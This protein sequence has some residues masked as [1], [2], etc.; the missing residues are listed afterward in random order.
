MSLPKFDG[1]IHYGVAKA[2]SENFAVEIVPSKKHPGYY[3]IA[4]LCL[5]DS[6]CDETKKPVAESAVEKHLQFFLKRHGLVIDDMHWHESTT[7][8]PILATQE[9]R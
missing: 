1:K 4:I 9:N 5:A 7:G 2:Y 6:F 8:E 3:H